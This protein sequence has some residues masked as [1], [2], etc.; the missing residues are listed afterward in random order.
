MGVAVSFQLQV[1]DIGIEH[2]GQEVAE[3]KNA[4]EYLCVP[5]N[6]LGVIV[7]DLPLHWDLFHNMRK[8]KVIDD[9]YGALR[10]IKPARN[11]VAQKDF[12]VRHIHAVE[13]IPVQCPVK[14]FDMARIMEVDNAEEGEDLAGKHLFCA[15]FWIR[16]DPLDQILQDL[17]MFFDG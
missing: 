10:Y 2:I 4:F 13:N 8:I 12:L 14:I 15:V 7:R 6:R 11:L 3:I 9:L 16:Y 17:D 1:A 5:D